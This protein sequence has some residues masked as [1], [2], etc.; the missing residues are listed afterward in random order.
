MAHVT[1]HTD[2]CT[3]THTCVHARGCSVLQGLI[4]SFL[5]PW[6]RAGYRSIWLSGGS[7]SGGACGQGWLCRDPHPLPNQARCLSRSP[8]Q[9]HGSTR[10]PV[11]VQGQ[12]LSLLGPLRTL[13]GQ[14]PCTALTS[15]P[16]VLSPYTVAWA[17][18]ESF[19]H[20][21]KAQPRGPG[22]RGREHQESFGVIQVLLL[23]QLSTC[24]LCDLGKGAQPL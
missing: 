18:S 17:G 6:E 4:T 2:T 1:R 19:T 22:V 9:H 21:S 23:S 14:G 8:P 16:T 10:K 15:A 12:H 3:C 24:R 5:G 13:I 20:R 11:G 7:Y